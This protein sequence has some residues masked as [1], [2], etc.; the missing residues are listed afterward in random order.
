MAGGLVRHRPV[1]CGSAKGHLRLHP[2][3]NAGQYG[4]SVSTWFPGK[5]PACGRRSE[6]TKDEPYG[7]NRIAVGAMALAGG[8]WM[9]APIASSAAAE[10]TGHSAVPGYRHIVEIMMENSSYSTIIGN[11]LAPNINTWQASNGLA[12]SYYGVNPPER[13]ELYGEHCRKLL[14]CPG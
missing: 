14:R 12:T 1:M 8:A 2:L 5:S 3:A 7:L 11:T 6:R 9:L 13:A 10:H 4:H